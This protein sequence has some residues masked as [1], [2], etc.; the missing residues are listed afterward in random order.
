ME[1]PP[2]ALWYTRRGGA[3]RG[4]F[5]TGLVRRFVL[6]GRLRPEDEVSL[7][8]VAWSR[9][10]EHPELVPE[11][12]RLR[13][14]PEGRERYLLALRRED[15]RRGVERRRGPGRGGRRRG[16]RRAEEPEALRRARALRPQVVAGGRLQRLGLA[17][18]VLLAGVIVALYAV[19]PVRSPQPSLRCDAPPAPGVDWRDCVFDG[20]RLGAVDLARAR[21]RSARLARADLA[22]ARLTAADLSFA[23]LGGAR[24]AHADL[25]GARLVG[26]DLA[27]ADLAGADLEGADLAYAN[28]TGARLAGAH[29]DGA[30]LDKAVW[31]DRRICAVGSRGACR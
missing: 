17:V 6:L 7:D 4:P 25:R 20:V 10:G 8:R 31:V 13:D 27:G 1:R 11:E 16:E 19:A 29:L 14:T 26:A 30:R 22:G 18:A 24:L 15:E 2:H 23:A 12:L 28:L 5:P 21:L 3:V 9:L